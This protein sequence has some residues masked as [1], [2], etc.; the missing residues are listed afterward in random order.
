MRYHLKTLE[1]IDLRGK[2][3]L[4]RVAYDITLAK[5][6]SQMIVPT[7]TRIKATLPT[8]NYLL[9]QGCS[10]ALLSYLRRPGGKIVEDWRMKPVADKLAELLGCQVTAL[11]DCV[12]VE[13]KKAIAE[14]KAGDVVM[15]E[16]VRFHPGEESAD[17]EFAK[18]L[19]S[20][21][22]VIVYDAFAQAMRV[23]ASTTGILEC[24]PSVAGRLFETEIKQLSELLENPVHPFIALM[25]G[26]KISDRVGAMTNLLKKAD[27][28]L[29]GGALANTFFLAQGQPVG[30]SLV[31]DIFVDT[32]RGEKKDYLEIARAI[33]K[34]AG[35]KIHLPVDMIAA[36]NSESTDTKIVNLDRGESLP[37]TWAYFDI[38]PRTVENYS[39]I[40]QTGKLIFGNGPMGYF[41]Q[42]QFANGTRQLAESMISAHAITV[43][44]GGDTESIVGR[45]GF[46]G[47]FTH[48]STGGGAS[49][50]FLAGKEFPVIKYLIKDK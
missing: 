39:K 21:F 24:L 31:E 46:E 16:N 4:L 50:E 43:I 40:L 32:A 34:I 42:A 38:G 28:I 26:A 22:D 8:I 12:G 17:Q 5:V 11:R 30:K 45:F 18:E 36:P 19:T 41:E 6:N 27:Y 23:H 33:L 15:L 9:E 25:G 35:E 14:M 49:L 48:V 3:V 10:I 47:Q 13:V 37:G 44:G 2:K 7:D 20:G 29:I 1:D